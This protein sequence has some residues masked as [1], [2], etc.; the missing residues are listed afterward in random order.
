M[1]TPNGRGAGRN[2][3]E[4]CLELVNQAM[5][6]L[7]NNDKECVLRKIE[8]LIKN[9]CHDGRLIGKEIANKVKDVVHEL[10]LVSDY[11]FR[12]GLLK[13]LKDLGISKT[14][15]KMAAHTTRQYLDK[16]LAKCNI[17][18]EGRATRNDIVRQLEDLL[19]R[20]GWSETRMCEELWQFI[21]VDVNAFRRHRIEP[22]SW[23]I[24]L[25]GLGNLKHPYWLGLRASDLTIWKYDGGVRL[26][27]ET[28]STVDAIFF[29]TLLNMIKTPS[30]VIKWERRAPA[31]KYVSISITL[32]YYVVLGANAWPWPELSA[33][34]L[35][36]ILDG[37]TDEELAEFV[38]GLLDGDGSILVDK[39]KE[40]NVNIIVRIAACKNCP[41]RVIDILKEIIA[42]RFGIVG[43]IDHLGTDDA[44]VFYGEKAVKLLRRVVR[45]IHHPIKRLRTELFLALYDGKISGDEFTKLYKPTKYKRGEPDIKRNSG[46]DVLIRAA[47]QTHTHGIVMCGLKSPMYLSLIFTLEL[48]NVFS[49]VVLSLASSSVLSISIAITLGRDGVGSSIICFVCTVKHGIL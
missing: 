2:R 10:W 22:C 12:C 42:R 25:E 9:Q 27:L 46:L 21:G 36:R 3:L 34:E 41:K 28:S 17:D 32:T 45:Y 7:E 20:M 44:L 38:G 39:D 49:I 11:E 19:R 16:C 29:P 37:F 33:D 15:V 30:L 18:W 23:L 26:M 4:L 24:G 31:A 13:M 14:W 5:R 40:E 8:Y 1:T 35:K 6:C 47:P 43:T 48:F